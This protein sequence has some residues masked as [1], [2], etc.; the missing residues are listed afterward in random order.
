MLWLESR[1]A[2]EGSGENA[3]Q[4]LQTKG[5]SLYMEASIWHLIV[6]P[7]KITPAL[8]GPMMLGKSKNRSVRPG[9]LEASLG[10]LS[11]SAG[12]LQPHM[13]IGTAICLLLAM[14]AAFATSSGNSAL[15]LH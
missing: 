3:L 15:Y 6:L 12:F 14:K 5:R 7:P 13:H 8:Q 10:C 9:L 2:L 11:S 1:M 4:T